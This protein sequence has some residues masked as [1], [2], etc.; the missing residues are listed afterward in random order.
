MCFWW[1]SYNNT[2][3]LTK[4]NKLLD[5][6][7][8]FNQRLEWEQNVIWLGVGTI[9]FQGGQRVLLLTYNYVASY[10]IQCLRNTTD[11]HDRVVH[12]KDGN[13]SW[14]SNNIHPAGGTNK[15]ILFMANLID[16]QC[17][18]WAFQPLKCSSITTFPSFPPMFFLWR[19]TEAQRMASK[20]WENMLPRTK[21]EE[22]MLHK[23]KKNYGELGK[24]EEQT[25]NKSAMGRVY[26]IFLLFFSVVL[27]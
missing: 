10:S 26:H 14:E 3:F 22:K 1:S 13:E 12:L 21:E 5:I 15:G 27:I 16:N 24:L 18:L 25:N 20:K 19:I 17:C 9:E 2:H 11:R 6:L 4:Q 7:F 23:R 8:S